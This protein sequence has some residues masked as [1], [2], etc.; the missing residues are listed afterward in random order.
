[1]KNNKCYKCKSGN[2]SIIE[3][4]NT[5]R[6]KDYSYVIPVNKELQGSISD[7]VE[8]DDY[9]IIKLMIDTNTKIRKYYYDKMCRDMDKYCSI[10]AF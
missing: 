9:E 6:V 4:E 7:Y 1:M 5:Y 10:G 2:L 8:M 3:R